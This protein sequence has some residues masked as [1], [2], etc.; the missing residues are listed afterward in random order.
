M[1]L[2]TIDVYG[3]LSSEGL[4]EKDFAPINRLSVYGA[5]RA[6][7]ER[8]FIELGASITRLPTVFGSTMNKGVIFDIIHNDCRFLPNQN[9]EMQFF[10]L[11]NLK[12]I[13]DFQLVQKIRILNI[14]PPRIKLSELPEFRNM[15]RESYLV[16]PHRVAYEM[17]SLFLSEL[18]CVNER[19][20]TK[21][22][23]LEDINK[24]IKERSSK[25]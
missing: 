13:L 14:A 21:S 2:S 20:F 6:W 23:L 16:E 3:D 18:K 1:V 10:D 15:S 25:I 8:M 12:S 24:F 7:L 5:N 17:R 11:M 22:S 9:S 19:A 4:T